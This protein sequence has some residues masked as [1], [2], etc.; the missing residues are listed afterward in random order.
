MRTTTDASLDLETGEEFYKL[1]IKVTD[2]GQPIPESSTIIVLVTIRDINN[3]SP[4]FIE[5]A[6]DFIFASEKTL[7][8]TTV[9]IVKAVDP[10]LNSS[11]RYEIIKP[12]KLFDKNNLL[13]DSNEAIFIIDSLNGTMK[14]NKHLDYEKSAIITGMN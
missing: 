10:D 2:S 8:N 4:K 3:K 6:T 9:A 12:L 14:L 11:V 1:T 13:T 5:S 7:V